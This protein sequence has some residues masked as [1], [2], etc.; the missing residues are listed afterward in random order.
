MFLLVLIILLL[1]LSFVASGLLSIWR[2]DFGAAV[3]GDVVWFALSLAVPWLFAFAFCLLLFRWGPGTTTRFRDVWPGAALVATGL[4]VL[5]AGF[6]IYVNYFG[7]FDVVYGALGGVLL[8][9]LFVYWS[10]YL[11]LFGAEMSAEYRAAMQAQPA[12]DATTTPASGSLVTMAT[13]FV[14]GLFVR[15]R[16]P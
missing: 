3:F 1:V 4:E 5:K 8:F 15:Q 12:A 13:D 7:S 2:Q 14:K 6:G 10:A 11:F 9:M 16:D